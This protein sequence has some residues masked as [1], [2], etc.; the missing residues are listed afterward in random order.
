MDN[1]NLA[2]EVYCSV[3]AGEQPVTQYTYDSSLIYYKCRIIQKGDGTVRIMPAV[4][5]SRALDVYGGPN[6]TK[7]FNGRSFPIRKE[8]ANPYR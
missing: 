8:M 1:T 5:N 3:D 7:T 6:T 4:S 2:M